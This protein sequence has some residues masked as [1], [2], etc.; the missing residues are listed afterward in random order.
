MLGS[1][2]AACLI[3]KFIQ[4]DEMEDCRGEPRASP[5]LCISSLIANRTVKII[6]F[7]MGKMPDYRHSLL[8]RIIGV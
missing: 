3:Q 5:F 4:L 6:P 2:A 8:S 1:S 7:L